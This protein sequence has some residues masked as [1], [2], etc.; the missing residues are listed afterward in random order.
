MPR[1]QRIVNADTQLLR[2]TEV[3]AE[4]DIGLTSVYALMARGELRWI[5]VLGK[6]RRIRREDLNA[7]LEA[8]L[9]GGWN[10]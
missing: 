7:F 10:Q 8:R 6:G 9:R 2:P 3:A 4:L 5:K 1:A